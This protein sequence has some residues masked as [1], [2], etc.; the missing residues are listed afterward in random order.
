VLGRSSSGGAREEVGGEL[1]TQDEVIRW[2]SGGGRPEG[3][4]Q[5]L[6]EACAREEIN[7]RSAALSPGH[8]L[9]DGEFG[10]ISI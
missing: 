3:D 8:A 6:E 4:R 9:P 7:A 1:G 2:G 10:N 5:E